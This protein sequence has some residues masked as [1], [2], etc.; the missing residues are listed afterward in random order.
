MV[1]CSLAACGGEE[2][3]GVSRNDGAAAA[4]VVNAPE[5]DDT[6]LGAAAAALR[7]TV[8]GDSWREPFESILSGWRGERQPMTDLIR[9][10]YRQR[11]YRPVFLKGL[12]PN[13]GAAVMVKA[14]R[15]IPSHGLPHSPY[16]PKVVIPLFG[17]LALDPEAGAG[18]L[19]EPIGDLERLA[20]LEWQ[21]PRSIYK[22]PRKSERVPEV[23]YRALK[24]VPEL[25]EL[26]S[27]VRCLLELVTSSAESGQRVDR[28]AASRCLTGGVTAEEGATK[29]RAA[30]DQRLEH[31][32]S[33]ALLDALLV[34]AY[35]Q[36]TID[37][38]IDYRMHPFRS[39]GPRNR[40]RLPTE[41]RDRLLKTLSDT[42]DGE[43]FAKLLRSQVPQVPEYDQTREAL[44]RY[45]RLM[46]A[47]EQ[48][49][50][51]ATQRLEKGDT[52]KAVKA[53][54][55]RLAAEGFYDGAVDGDFGETLHEAV[56]HFQKNRQLVA[57]GVVGDDTVEILNIAFEWRVKQL[58]TA[59]GR[60]RES[61][62]ARGGEPE[63][64]VRV[65]LPAFELEVIEGGKT[66]RVHRVIVGSNK[67]VKDPLNN[68][69]VWH[70]RRT[71]IFDT[72][73]N[74]VVLNPNWIVPE[75]IRVEEISVKVQESPTYLEENN[76]KQIGELLVQGPG[77][78]NPLGTVKFSLESTD[79]IYLHDTD[80]RWLFNEV[81]RDFSH[82]CIRVD[83][84]A[85]LAKF[86]L[87]PQG[88]SDERID[89][90]IKEGATLNV[91][92]DSP[93]HT[94]VEYVTVGFSKLGETLFYRDLYS[95]DVAY[96]KKRT[97]ITRKFP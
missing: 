67:R 82:G 50:L 78:T 89:S 18:T 70:Q 94:Y 26:E 88:V 11:D 39:L 37:F 22:R 8:E 80:K 29:V 36:W 28:E 75:L 63:L 76:F 57:G 2:G 74:Q 25:R 64:Y 53:L 27:S 20:K 19:T 31:L 55:R 85:K 23:S 17:A 47:E 45:V 32:S 96:W 12:W 46:D 3:E 33:L 1:S 93:I 71:K 7:P 49:E 84:P 90:R 92:V 4:E 35:Y 38:S 83:E 58:I 21:M 10:T 95:Y 61:P 86:I 81:V 97:P 24:N 14:V 91:D 16:R 44:D 79:S 73:L 13:E 15:E 59:L 6:P 77:A 66:T 9:E 87:S 68:D 41:A 30:L 69:V 5:V 43:A 65:N 52:G 54:Q 56:V 34:Q 51:R 72:K 42:D 62:I 48:E 40:H 60:W